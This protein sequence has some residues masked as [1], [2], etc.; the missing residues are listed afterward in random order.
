MK[1]GEF[2]RSWR[3]AKL[4]GNDRTWFSRSGNFHSMSG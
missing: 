4:C 3:A 2:T 1:S